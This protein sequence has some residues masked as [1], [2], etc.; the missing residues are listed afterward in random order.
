VKLI[1]QEQEWRRRRSRRAR[2]G[3]GRA[4]RAR[5]LEQLGDYALLG[6]HLRSRRFN[7]VVSL[8]LR[9]TASE[10][11]VG[12]KKLRVAVRA[13]AELKELWKTGRCAG[14]RLF[15]VEGRRALIVV[16]RGRPTR[17]GAGPHPGD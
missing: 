16:R 14:P 8:A 12:G 5:E 4:G 10:L 13:G 6:T 15:A 3:Q 11:F 9:C 2:L 1:Q 7:H 17:G